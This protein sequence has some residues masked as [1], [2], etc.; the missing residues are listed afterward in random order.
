MKNVCRF[1]IYNYIFGLS[2]YK[3]GKQNE[4]S[5]NSLGSYFISIISAHFYA[6]L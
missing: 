3:K 4:Y 6:N 2:Y 5:D 1:Q